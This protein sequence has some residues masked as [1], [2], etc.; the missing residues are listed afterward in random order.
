MCCSVYYCQ[1]REKKD[2]GRD[3]CTVLC[4][5]LRTCV[6][7]CVLLPTQTR[8]CLPPSLQRAFERL[9]GHTLILEDCLEVTGLRIDEVVEHNFRKLGGWDESDPERTRA[10]VAKA[11]V[12][13]MEQLLSTEAEPMAG[14]DEALAFIKAQGVRLAVASSSPMRLIEAGLK[15]LGLDDGVF[16]VTCS[17][18]FEALGKPHPGVYLTCCAKLGVEAHRCVAIEDS[19]NGVIA[20]KAGRLRCIAV[21]SVEDRERPAF[22]VADAKLESLVGIDAE[23]WN[24]LGFATV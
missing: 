13:E 7:Q 24:S 5:V 22:A 9:T 3:I 2:H 4:C 14:L 12:D 15:R 6:L 8:R 10:A 20:A 18:Q 17:A 23:V 21:P 11:I 16:E 19:L 1:E